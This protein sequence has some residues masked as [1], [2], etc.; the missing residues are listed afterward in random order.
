VQPEMRSS[1]PRDHDLTRALRASLSPEFLSPDIRRRAQAI[2]WKDLTSTGGPLTR[3]ARRLQGQ[4]RYFRRSA[5]RQATARTG[6]PDPER[7]PLMP[8]EKYMV[9]VA[10]HFAEQVAI[11]QAL[12]VIVDGDPA[13]SRKRDAGQLPG[14]QRLLTMTD[15]TLNRRRL[16]LPQ[17]G[18]ES[19]P[20]SALTRAAMKVEEPLPNPLS[21][22]P[23]EQSARGLSVAE[24]AAGR[25]PDVSGQPGERSEA[26]KA[27]SRTYSQRP[28]QSVRS[29]R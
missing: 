4:E 8:G 16:E 27:T 18:V 19:A 25:S 20:W 21:F 15:V 24:A 23:V 12:R 17:V 26:V 14:T 29:Q 5:E 13:L 22:H 2:I 9:P 11:A 7:P 10:E 28:S 1:D 6:T 3:L